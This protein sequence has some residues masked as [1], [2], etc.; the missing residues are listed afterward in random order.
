MDGVGGSGDVVGGSYWFGLGFCRG[1]IEFEF[2]GRIL[3]VFF[4]FF[5]FLGGGVLVVLWDCLGVGDGLNSVFEWFLGLE[6]FERALKNCFEMIYS[7]FIESFV[8][9]YG[10]S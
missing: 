3:K 4:L 8:W 6:R 7:G 1:F 2:F 10:V 5:F 9:F